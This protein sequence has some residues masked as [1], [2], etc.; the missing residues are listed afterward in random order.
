MNLVVLDF[1]GATIVIHLVLK[2]SL[3]L[4]LNFSLTREIPDSH[5]Y[6]VG[7]SIVCG[8]YAFELQ[9][10]DLSPSSSSSSSILI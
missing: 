1:K 7:L 9:V 10:C 4:F 8:L 3:S 2:Y 6:F 5:P